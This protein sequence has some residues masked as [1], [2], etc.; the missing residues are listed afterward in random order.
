[1]VKAR[2][3]HPQQDALLTRPDRPL[4]MSKLATTAEE[5]IARRLSSLS[6]STLGRPGGVIIPARGAGAP[7]QARHLPQRFRDAL[8][9]VRGNRADAI[10]TLGSGPA[11]VNGAPTDEDC[12]DVSIDR[13]QSDANDAS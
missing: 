12:D 10:H 5:A 2:L 7:S 4:F 6:W 1:M 9:I 8:K 13:V 11:N 3:D